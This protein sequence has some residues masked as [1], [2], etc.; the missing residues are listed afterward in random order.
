MNSLLKLLSLA[1]LAAVVVPSCLYFT[2][3]L[4]HNAAKWAAL[5]ATIL[6]FA[7]TPLWMGRAREDALPATQEASE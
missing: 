4:E 3:T 1:A 6:W 7:V 5:L 2:G